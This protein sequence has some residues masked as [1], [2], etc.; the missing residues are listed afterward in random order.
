MSEPVDICDLLCLDLP[1]AESIRATVPDSAT[2]A[3]AA[4]AARGLGDPTRLSIAAALAA[5][6]E[7]CVCD[8][9]WVVGLSQG[10]VSHHLRQLKN[11]S[12]VSSRRQGKLVMYQLTERGRQ[13][14]D[15]VLTG[16]G[17]RAGKEPDRV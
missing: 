15:S 8:M 10:L 17:A 13:L 7:L 4:A 3:A 9:A 6:D 12:L 16:A 5:G 1:H 11:A 14:T 2:I